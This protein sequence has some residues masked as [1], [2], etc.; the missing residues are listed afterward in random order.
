MTKQQ[1]DITQC[2]SSDLDLRRHLEGNQ[3]ESTVQRDDNPTTSI[4]FPRGVCDMREQT[5]KYVSINPDDSIRECHMIGKVTTGVS[6]LNLAAHHQAGHAVMAYIHHEFLRIGVAISEEGTG[7]SILQDRYWKRQRE[8]RSQR[9]SLIRSLNS[10][11]FLNDACISLAGPIAELLFLR[12]ACLESLFY[13][14]DI[15]SVQRKLRDMYP[16]FRRE[17]WG[18]LLCFCL[19]HTTDVLSSPRNWRAVTEIARQ[20]IKH[21]KISGE[22]IEKICGL[23]GVA[24]RRIPPCSGA[25]KGAP[26]PTT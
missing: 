4:Q 17:E 19:S 22:V 2:N 23:T 26:N 10:D 20:L 7:L 3:D 18:F 16:G 9:Q 8:Q 11:E 6:L 13:S 14:P 1:P 24:R 5:R 15:E 25:A 12:Y 21:R